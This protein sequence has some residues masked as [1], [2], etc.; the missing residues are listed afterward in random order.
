MA[1]VGGGG[2]GNV[3]GANPSGTGSSLNYI[4]NHAYAYSGTFPSTAAAVTMLQFTTGSE[5]IKGQLVCN[6][7]I[8]F[9]TGN[10]DSGVSSGFQVSI[11]GQVVSIMKTDS[12][13][14]DMPSNTIQELILAP[15]TTVKVERI[16]SGGNATFLNT[17][18]FTGRI[19]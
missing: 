5:Y 2:V 18:T 6:A 12:G 17:A 16:A 10:I 11:D 8:D 13:A 15:F 14:E 3:A 9:S 7:A 19:Y 4:G 1:R